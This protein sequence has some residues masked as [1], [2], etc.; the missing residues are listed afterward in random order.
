MFQGAAGKTR[1]QKERNVCL[2]C[3]MLDTK[4]D[5]GKKSHKSL[6]RLAFRCIDLRYERIAGYPRS[7]QQMTNWEFAGLYIAEQMFER[8]DIQIR[9][10]T[11][12]LLCTLAGVKRE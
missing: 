8:E 5:E 3:P 1:R 6:E 2:V 4:T 12:E 10:N 7:T 11:V 9:Q